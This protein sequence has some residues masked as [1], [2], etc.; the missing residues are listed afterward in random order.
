MN[1]Y[2]ILLA[3]L[4]AVMPTEYADYYITNIKDNQFTIIGANLQN[5]TFFFDE[6]GNLIK[7]E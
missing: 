1:V 6:N 3:T 2:K 7:W 4:Q 5:I